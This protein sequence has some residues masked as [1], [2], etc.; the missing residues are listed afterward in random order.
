M[1]SVRISSDESW[2]M[3]LDRT[4][5]EDLIVAVVADFPLRKKNWTPGEDN[6]HKA[7]LG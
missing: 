2:M 3:P 4:H 6:R 1:Y 5:G 7:K